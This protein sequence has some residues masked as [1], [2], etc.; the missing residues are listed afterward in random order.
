[1]CELWDPGQVFC[2]QNLPM[3]LGLWSSVWKE[4]L[5]MNL[6]KKQLLILKLLFLEIL[7][8]PDAT[9]MSSVF[10]TV[11]SDVLVG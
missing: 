2:N 11:G 10:Q 3:S 6:I 9:L 4:D 1:M 5:W 7:P 8:F